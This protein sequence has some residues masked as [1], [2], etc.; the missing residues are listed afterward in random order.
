MTVLRLKSIVLTF[1][2]SHLILPNSIMHHQSEDLPWDLLTSNLRWAPGYIPWDIRVLN[3]PQLPGRLTQNLKDG[4]ACGFTNLHQTSPIQDEFAQSF[5]NAVK[6]SSKRK[7][8]EYPEQYCPPSP[9]DVLLGDE[10]VEKIEPHLSKLRKGGHRLPCEQRTAFA[11]LHPW[12]IDDHCNFWD[13]NEIG[14]LNV[15]IVKILLKLGE[16]DPILRACAHP[17]VGLAGWYSA[18]E[19]DCNVSLFVMQLCVIGSYCTEHY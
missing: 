8:A 17:D 9:S 6:E 1:Q 11:F 15:E 2:S 13:C 16:L 18:A 5:S 7:R 14:F 12:D 3:L 4:C 19:C 10:L